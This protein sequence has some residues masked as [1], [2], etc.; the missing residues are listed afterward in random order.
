MKKTTGCGAAVA[1]LLLAG[2]LVAADPLAGLSRQRS[3]E[4]ETT[5]TSDRLEFD[6]K[7][8][9]A[10]FEGNVRVV[11]PQFELT[12]DKMLIFFERTNDVR[13]VDAIGNVNVISLDRTARCGRA[14]Y[15]RANGSILLQEQ[16]VVTKGPHTLRG[17]TIRIWLA[18]NRVEVD[19]SVQLEG[20]AG[21]R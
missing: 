5:I 12:S 10:L 1:T 14:T 8:Y 9:V 6:Y 13:R 17:E 20:S 18:D 11:D 21:S 15:T 4:G 2:V 19:G 7:D 3:V 16:P